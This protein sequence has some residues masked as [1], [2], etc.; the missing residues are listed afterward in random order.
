VGTR[1]PNDDD[2]EFD[3]L[4]TGSRD[5]ALSDEVIDPAMAP[6]IEAGGGVA[7]GFE[8]SEAALVENATTG[9]PDGTERILEDAGGTE[10]E[11]DRG[12]Y[13]DADHERHADERP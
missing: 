5:G 11:E 4:A 12:V 2:P 13:G 9:P 1:R 10:A 7:E 8:Q 3:D 6:V